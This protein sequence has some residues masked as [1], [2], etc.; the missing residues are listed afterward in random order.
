M[1]SGGW[2]VAATA[3]CA[4]SADSMSGSSRL[5][6]PMSSSRLMSTGS[7]AG[8]RT[9]GALRLSLSAIN[10]V[11]SVDRSL[12]ACS[13]SSKIQS[14]SACPR[15]SAVMWLGRDGQHPIRRRQGGVWGGGG[16]EGGVW[17]GGGGFFFFSSCWGGCGAGALDH[18]LPFG[19]FCADEVA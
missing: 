3:A 1:P 16:G 17:V 14:K 11:S 2:R 18:G 12:G 10:W 4:A 15:I 5:T 6:K 7:L 9:T 8:G 19:D 13:L